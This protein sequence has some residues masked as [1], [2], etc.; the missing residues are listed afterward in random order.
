MR[1]TL[2]QISVDNRSIEAN[3][4][5]IKETIR[6]AADEKSD[7]LLTPEGSLSG[8]THQFDTTAAKNALAEVTAYAAE[9]KLGLALGTCM[10][11]DDGH[12]YNQLR[13]YEKDGTYLGCHTKTLRCGQGDPVQGEVNHYAVL[14]LRVFTFQGITISGL[15]CN[16]M[17]ANP[18]CTPMEDTHLA[19]QLA[20]MGAKV[21]FHAV[22]GGRDAS[23]FSQ[24]LI[25]TF[26]EVHVLMLANAHKLTICTVDNA[27]PEDIGVS[28]VGGV[29]D[30]NGTW[31][32]R[33][34]VT[35]RQVAT[36]ELTI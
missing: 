26:H 24:G 11:E 25:R 20:R 31:L 5:R 21:I 9:H 12:C 29:A 16:D 8:Y 17:W 28:S 22:N 7:I 35:G 2:A 19:R 18:S 32:H 6:Q 1:V 4:L 36:F 23:D 33:L 27:F 13:F 15:I 30:K 34:P 14:P 10:V 3:L